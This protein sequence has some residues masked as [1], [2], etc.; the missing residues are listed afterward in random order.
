MAQKFFLKFH[1]FFRCP[2][3]PSGPQPSYSGGLTITLRYTTL[4]RTPLD[5]WS[6]RHIDLYLTT[7]NTHETDTH[8]PGG[9]RNR[10]SNKRSAADPRVGPRGAKIPYTMIY[11]CDDTEKENDDTVGED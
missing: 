9:I 8:T 7:H 3:I 5:E 1:I 11:W 2:T 6:A 10:T 4:G